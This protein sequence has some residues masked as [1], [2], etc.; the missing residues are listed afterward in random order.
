VAQRVMPHLQSACCHC[1]RLQLHVIDMISHHASFR[2][3]QAAPLLLPPGSLAQGT[4][5]VSQRPV[6]TVPA[7]PMDAGGRDGGAVAAPAQ[8]GSWHSGQ[9]GP[10]LLVPTEGSSHGGVSFQQLMV[11]PW[12]CSCPLLIFVILPPC[13]FMMCSV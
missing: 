13:P 5:A 1:G 8:D 12:S 6:P 2:A 3:L 11:G 7:V 4:P 9:Q 10:A